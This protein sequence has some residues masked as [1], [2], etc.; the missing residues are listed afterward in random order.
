MTRAGDARPIRIPFA[1]VSVVTPWLQ[2]AH[3]A[4]RNRR[5]F[6]GWR[7]WARYEEDLF[8]FTRKLEK[9]WLRND[10]RTDAVTL[11]TVRRTEARAAYG[12]LKLTWWAWGCDDCPI[13][14]ELAFSALH[15]ALILHKVLDWTRG[16]PLRTPA[17]AK[18]LLDEYR[19]TPSSERYKFSGLRIREAR[20]RVE[21]AAMLENIIADYRQYEGAIAPGT[22]G[23]DLLRLMRE[24]YF[25]F[26]GDREVF[27]EYPMHRLIDAAIEQLPTDI[28]TIR[29]NDS[30]RR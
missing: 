21:A 27:V 18:R 19:R 4:F 23:E 17:Q 5:P 6:V 29:E 15:V 26:E 11:W 12:Y 1:T 24:R 8:G 7:F 25:D 10:D 2:A 30:F 22:V 3:I 14:N 28:A 9:A 13:S 20:Q 16:K